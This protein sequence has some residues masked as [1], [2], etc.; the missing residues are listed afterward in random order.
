[1]VLFGGV[2]VNIVVAAV[3]NTVS[4]FRIC[5]CGRISSVSLSAFGE[6]ISDNRGTSD[7]KCE[8]A[9]V[10]DGCSTDDELVTAG[11][12]FSTGAEARFFWDWLIRKKNLMGPFCK[13]N[14]KIHIQRLILG[15]GK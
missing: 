8:M 15:Q 6:E 3:C 9:D 13:T 12:C 10:K 11:S 7:G 2:C 14:K 1:M 4:G 5:A